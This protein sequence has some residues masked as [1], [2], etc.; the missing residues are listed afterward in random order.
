[1][2]WTEAVVLVLTSSTISVVIK[3]V[4]D[5][6]RGT[7]KA[8]RELTKWQVWGWS[9]MTELAKNGVNVNDYPAPPEP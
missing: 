9:L 4:F 8:A 3:E 7:T 5:I 1:M 2:D 6:A